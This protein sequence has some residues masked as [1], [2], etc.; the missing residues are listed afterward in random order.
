MMFFLMTLLALSAD[1][2]NASHEQAVSNYNNMSL[3]QGAAVY[4]K[5]LDVDYG[6]IKLHMEDGVFYPAL[7]GTGSLG[8][9][10]KGKARFVYKPIDF[11]EI[12]QLRNH[13]R[14]MAREVSEI[15]LD[16]TDVYVRATSDILPMI[17]AYAA[18]DA[19]VAKVGSL[20][21][22]DRLN[23]A[24]NSH[25]GS[26]VMRYM[27]KSADPDAFGRELIF[28]FKT[29]RWGN[30]IL[31]YSD[32]D[33]REI[34]LWSH[35][36]E[37]PPPVRCWAQYDR[38]NEHP[39]PIHAAV[40]EKKVLDIR[41][42]DMTMK[43]PK[44]LNFDATVAVD[45]TA[46]VDL[47]AVCFD[48]IGGRNKFRKVRSKQVKQEIKEVVLVNG[49]QRTPLTYVHYDG[50]LFM[51]NPGGFKKGQTYRLEI[52]YHSINACTT[53]QGV[54]EFVTILSTFPWFPQYGFMDRY[55]MNWKVGTKAPYMPVTSG[56]TVQRWKEDGYNW[57]HSEEK[58]LINMASL[59]IGEYGFDSDTST[60]PAIHVYTAHTER[61][62]RKEILQIS[63]EVIR[64]YESL[65]GPY[66]YEELDLAQMFPGVGFAQAPPGLVQIT[67]EAFWTQARLAEYYRKPA[68]FLN[69]FLAHEIAHEWWGHKLG[70]NAPESQ[71]FSESFAQYSSMLFM[72]AWKGEEGRD[73]ELD[74][75]DMRL[76]YLYENPKQVNLGPVAMGYSR[77]G[78]AGGGAYYAKGPYVLHTLRYMMG[79][80]A[81]FGALKNFQTQF[82]NK[83][84]STY[85][86]LRVFNLQSGKDW[87][88][89]F[90]DFLIQKGGRP[91]TRY[92]VR[93]FEENGEW[94]AEFTFQAQAEETGVTLLAPVLFEMGS[95]DQNVTGRVLVRAEGNTA[96]VK[97]AAKAKKIVP[98]PDRQVLMEF[99]KK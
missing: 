76:K 18:G 81:F 78:R 10:F 2:D 44:S 14:I 68:F 19:T 9:L 64:Y 57:V 82:A 38:A 72:Q 42:Y 87:T 36:E 17:N 8:G 79:D 93:Q 37:K 88:G 71:W 65:F 53:F 28:A 12:Q 62:K 13:S 34:S 41:H 69:H 31:K 46:L 7:K 25:F 60:R 43:V 63:R 26:Q 3:N 5:N 32:W 70:W 39:T 15:E 24:V 90:N 95:K 86:F 23:K 49:E 16:L 99:V 85:H 75:W 94:I 83:N 48:F 73:D 67:G 4:V 47:N 6:V 22:W 51:S 27:E 54:S 97:L 45:F 59:I 11:T 29:P 96:R 21:A 91:E 74:N 58:T 84:V 33:R 98:N 80:E 92:E 30:M 40:E 55:T 89:F 61:K 35:T 52:S 66:P 50:E 56:T 77:L 20:G 1:S